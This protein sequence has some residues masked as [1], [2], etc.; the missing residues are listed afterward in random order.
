MYIYI[1]CTCTTILQYKMYLFLQLH[2]K[3]IYIYNGNRD[4][5]PIA[6]SNLP[7]FQVKTYFAEHREACREIG[8]DQQPV[9]PF[10]IDLEDRRVGRPFKV[11][12]RRFHWGCGIFFFGAPVCCWFLRDVNIHKNSTSHPWSP[13]LFT[14]CSPW[15]NF[16]GSVSRAMSFSVR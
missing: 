14:P 6:A 7:A 1:T 5:H 4:L 9:F 13:W 12:G 15:L 11:I 10:H 2:T 3:C 16:R 8:V